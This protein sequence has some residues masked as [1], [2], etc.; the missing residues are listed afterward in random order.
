MRLMSLS[1]LR[2]MNARWSLDLDTGPQPLSSAVPIAEQDQ[3]SQEF[4]LQSSDASP[5]QWLAGLYY[6]HLDERYDPTT[7]HYGGGYSALLGGRIRQTLFSSGDVSSYAGYGQGTLPIGEATRLTLG[8][9]Y[10]D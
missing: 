6:I 7:S 4:Q 1:A 8:L 2:R 5:V 10:T 9:R 3:F